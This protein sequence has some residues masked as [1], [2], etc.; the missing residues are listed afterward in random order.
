MTRKKLIAAG[1]TVI[2][3]LLALEELGF[4]ITGTPDQCIAARG[5]EVYAADDPVTVLGLVKLVEI[6]SWDWRASD[7]EI[8]AILI[9]YHLG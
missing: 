4:T 7:A 1:N 5:D 8:D 2:P 3:A 6:K 9:K